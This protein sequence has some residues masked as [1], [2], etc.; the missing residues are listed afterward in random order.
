MNV[1]ITT[2]LKERTGQRRV[3]FAHQSPK[4]FHADDGVDVIDEE[5]HGAVRRDGG[6]DVKNRL[7]NQVEAP[8]PARTPHQR[9]LCIIHPQ[10]LR[11]TH[12][13]A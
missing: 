3:S 7:D 1:R 13:G 6:Y 2:N 10:A 8:I 9:E 5:Y 11:T 12:R 4:E